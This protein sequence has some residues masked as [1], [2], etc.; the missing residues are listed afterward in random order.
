VLAGKQI[1]RQ[2]RDDLGLI[3]SGLLASLGFWFLSAPDPRF[4]TGFILATA[5]F[6][7]SLAAAAWLYHP[8]LLSCA[9]Y[10]LL[11]LVAVS[12]ART[13]LRFRVE[14]FS[15]SPPQAAVFPL[16]TA[17]ETQGIRLWVTKWKLGDASSIAIDA[18]D[19]EPHSNQCW[20]QQ[21]PCTPYV[22][23]AALAH[24]HWPA[25]WFDPSG[26][27]LEPPRDYLPPPY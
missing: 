15:Y 25:T 27:A 26:P 17:Q 9:P 3:A 11:C 16:R 4:G 6:G 22:N 5:A 24:I 1:R 2:P 8:R 10:A 19:R 21:L 18:Q 14:A 13:L 7:L 12:G 20:A 23:P